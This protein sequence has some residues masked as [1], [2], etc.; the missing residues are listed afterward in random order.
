MKGCTKTVET[1]LNEDGK[2]DVK[3]EDDREE[4]L[5]PDRYTA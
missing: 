4:D 3:Q 5:W 2:L 1:M